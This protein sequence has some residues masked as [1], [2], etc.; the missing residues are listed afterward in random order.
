MC[1]EN[2]MDFIIHSQQLL[3]QSVQLLVVGSHKAEPKIEKVQTAVGGHEAPQ[4]APVAVLHLP[5][6]ELWVLYQ[7][8]LNCF[9]TGL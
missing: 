4:P 2:W 8:Q 5:F 1:Q 9:Q 7:G 6:A 3:Q